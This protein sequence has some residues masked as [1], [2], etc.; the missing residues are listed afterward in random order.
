MENEEFSRKLDEIFGYM[1]QVL[2]EKNKSYGGSAF[3]GEDILPILGNYFRLTDKLNRYKHLL[4]NLMKKGATIDSLKSDKELNPFGESLW[5]TVCDIL[6]YASI[7]L[8]ILDSKGLGKLSDDSKEGEAMKKLM[9]E[10]L[11]NEELNKRIIP[12]NPDHL[13]WVNPPEAEKYKAHGNDPEKS[14]PS[15][16]ASFE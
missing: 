13:R 8:A 9:E 16:V 14:S 2:V 12:E 3:E 10:V 1:K 6:G 4:L 15:I 5:D 7:G 11:G